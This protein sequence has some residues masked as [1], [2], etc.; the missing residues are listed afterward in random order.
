MERKLTGSSR[1]ARKFITF[2]SSGWEG[3]R[4]KALGHQKC[5]EVG[6]YNT[7]LMLKCPR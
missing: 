2:W 5:C 3:V 7:D 4:I 6:I 1:A